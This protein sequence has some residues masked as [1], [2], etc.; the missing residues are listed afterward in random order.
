MLHRSSMKVIVC[1]CTYRRADLLERLLISLRRIRIEGLNSSEIAVMI[2]DN[3]P[4]GQA[5]KVYE[6]VSTQFPIEMVFVEETRRGRPFARNRAIEESLRRNASFIAFIDDD[7]LPEPDW[8]L[9]LL[10]KQRETQAD[11]VCGAMRHNIKG[12]WPEWVK[13]SPIFSVSKKKF[14][15]KYSIPRG[16]GTFNVLIDC[17]L[18][19]NLKSAGPV[20]N[21]EFASCGGEDTDFF[22][23]ARRKGATF[24]LAEN[25]IIIRSFEDDR[26]KLNGMLRHAFNLGFYNMKL[27]K[28]HTNF[29]QVLARRNKALKKLAASLPAI[30]FSTFSMK[31]FTHNLYQTS[32]EIGV[33][34]SYYRKGIDHDLS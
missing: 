6:C 3:Y 33:L 15:T 10:E 9:R 31:R 32:R 16:I 18:L 5:R 2:V 13:N 20:F 4:D 23:R 27:M 30:I 22:I 29:R 8:I 24:A 28:N 17:R 26:L 7:D 1:I 11:I 34:C 19:A 25:S 12:D 14:E 21:P